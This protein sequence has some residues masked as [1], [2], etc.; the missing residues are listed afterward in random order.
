MKKYNFENIKSR[1][2]TGS[3]KWNE[4]LQYGVNQDDDIIPFSVADMEFELAPE[5]KESLIQR[6][7]GVALGYESPTES[8]Y[9]AIYN[10]EKRRH[11]WHINKEWIL[12]T[13]G[14]VEAFH[15]AVK[16]YTNPG[17]GVI[18]MTPVYYPMYHAIEINNRKLV[19]NPLIYNNG[20]YEIDFI[21]LEEK[22]KDDKNKL[23]ILCSPHNP[24]GR[25]WT[26]KELERISEICIKN[27][28]LVVSDEIHND[29]IM[30]GYNHTI[31]ANIS[32]QAEE[33]CIILTAPSKT[34]NL[35][36][37][38]TSNIF[39]PNKVLREKFEEEQKTNTVFPNTNLLG[40]VACQT[41][42]EKCKSWLDEV[43]VVIDRNKNLVNNFM[44][45][46]FPEVVVSPLEGTYL[47]W[48]NMKIFNLDY[49]ELERINKEEAKLFFDEGYMFGEKGAGFIRWNLACPTKYI[50][51][52][53]VR[54]KNIYSKYR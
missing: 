12:R 28:V 31:Y 13:H 9:D 6:I 51:E 1:M 48:I 36:G 5:I 24:T 22:A 14:V 40:L 10:W 11:N 45:K 32:K 33:N 3:S 20:K 37:M 49:K 16:V 7:E 21:D 43:I 8:Y 29:L 47:M 18:L 23:L 39:I 35:A 30:P 50:E 44:K 27:N 41:A 54:F 42:Y 38:Q 52:A 34:F 2:F 17:D 19:E 26:T 53:L 46:E 25:V 15:I 4:L